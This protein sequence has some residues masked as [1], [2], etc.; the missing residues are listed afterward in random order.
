MGAADDPRTTGFPLTATD[1]GGP[2]T[3]SPGATSFGRANACCLALS[4]SF[5]ECW[6]AR[7]EMAAVAPTAPAARRMPACIRRLRA[8]GADSNDLRFA[9]A[10]WSSATLAKRD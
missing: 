4:S 10:D 7:H 5:G 9:N 3:L 6:L 8:R 2:T 1:A